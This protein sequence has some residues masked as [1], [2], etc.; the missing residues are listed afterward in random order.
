MVLSEK[1]M[2][3]HISVSLVNVFFCVCLRVPTRRWILVVPAARGG[4]VRTS[5]LRAY[6]NTPKLKQRVRNSPVRGG[7][8]RLSAAKGAVTAI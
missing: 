4:G 2:I 1:Y 6:A 5:C 7:N 8:R 3:T